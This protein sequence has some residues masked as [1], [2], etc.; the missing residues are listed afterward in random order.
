[1]TLK[2]FCPQTRNVHT[3]WCSW[4]V[5]VH[6]LTAV[7][8]LRPARHVTAIVMMAAAALLVYSH[9][10]CTPSLAF[11]LSERKQLQSILGNRS[12]V[13]HTKLKL[14]NLDLR[15][16]NSGATLLLSQHIPLMKS[17]DKKSRVC[18]ASWIEPFMHH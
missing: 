12:Q 1:M 18:F 5:A 3:T 11:C 13:V 15:C 8:P 2:N 16:R 6:V 7:P 17:E 9:S 10:F 14:H 4:N